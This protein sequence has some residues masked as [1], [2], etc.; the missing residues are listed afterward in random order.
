MENKISGQINFI[1]VGVTIVIIAVLYFFIDINITRQ[2][3]YGMGIWAPLVFIGLK[4]LTLVVA[5]LSGSPLYPLVGVLFG[6]WPGLLYVAIGDFLGYTIT[7]GISRLFGRKIVEKLIGKKQEGLLARVVEH[8]GTTKGFFHITLTMFALPEL[9]S[10]G[11]GL[12]RLKYIKFISILWPLSLIASVVLVFLGSSL[13]FSNEVFV[14]YIG[15]PILGAVCVLVGSI[16]FVRS[17]KAKS[18]V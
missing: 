2:W 14:I 3:I 11:A 12:T 1:G 18:G 5:P 15:V 8:I 4:I 7:F 17:I 16:L 6:F 9:L 13:N 10:Y